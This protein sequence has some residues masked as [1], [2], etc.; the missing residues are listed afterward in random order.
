MQLNWQYKPFR[1]LTLDELYD[2]LKLRAKVFVLEQDCPYQDLDE[3][4]QPA[5]HLMGRSGDGE[6]M[7]YARILPAGI[8]YKEASIGRIITSRKIRGKGFGKILMEKAKEIV[9]HE[10]GA[11]P[12]RVSAQAHLSDYYTQFGFKKV[13]DLYLEDNIPHVEMLF[14]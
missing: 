12:I 8:S 10:W 3:K 2:I 1:K 9:K 5:L 4:D 14:Q 13:S 11:Q 7:A 6:L